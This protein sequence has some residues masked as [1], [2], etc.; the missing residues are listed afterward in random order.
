[1]SPLSVPRA[2]AG[3][4]SL[5]LITYP[6]SEWGR[7]L[8]ETVWAAHY[9]AERGVRV[10]QLRGTSFESSISLLRERL[11][12]PHRPDVVVCV[13]GDDL[14]VVALQ[15]TAATGTPLGLLPVGPANR[16]AATLGIPRHDARAAADIVLAGN[17]RR[18]DLGVIE[19]GAGATTPVSPRWFATAVHA[20]FGGAP[21][22]RYRRTWSRAGRPYPAARGT[23]S[24][25]RPFP[26][27]MT[28]AG[29]T[30]VERIET[31]GVL[32]S[33]GVNGGRRVDDGQLEIAPTGAA[34]RRTA[35]VALRAPGVGVVVDGAAVGQ[36]PI[37]IRAV[38]AAQ[39]VI[40]P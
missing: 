8:R 21:T 13:G 24:A 11:A 34:P 23:G 26:L 12:G 17:E 39:S 20:G 28:C 38:A 1:M 2:M 33:V 31:E 18:I 19:S 22:E 32:V 25:P 5:D 40:V 27:D 9:L 30:S 7:G 6:C 35:S 16:L 14:I 10:R 36:L 3:V 4:A 15:A 37:A 29:G